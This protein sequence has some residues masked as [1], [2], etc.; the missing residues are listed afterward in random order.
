MHGAYR[1]VG[2]RHGGEAWWQGGRGRFPHTP[3]QKGLGLRH[4]ALTPDTQQTGQTG[5][6][7]HPGARLGSHGD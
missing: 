5:K 7:Q 4:G 1:I 2:K 3:L 6:H